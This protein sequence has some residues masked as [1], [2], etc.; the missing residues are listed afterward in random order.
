MPVVWPNP[1]LLW[2]IMKHLGDGEFSLFY[3]ASEREMLYPDQAL[4][5]TP[6]VT[7]S[8]NTTRLQFAT[9]AP[10]PPPQ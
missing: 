8:K 10:I 1:N 9:H 2:S 3:Y 6:R 4:D 7:E 5:N